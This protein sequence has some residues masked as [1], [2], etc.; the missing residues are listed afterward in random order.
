MIVVTA[1]N[2][3]VKLRKGKWTTHGNERPR[4]FLTKCAANKCCCLQWTFYFCSYT[5]SFAIETIFEA[6]CSLLSIVL[7]TNNPL[8]RRPEYS[9]AMA[10]KKMAKIPS[11][12]QVQSTARSMYTATIKIKLTATSDKVMVRCDKPLSSKI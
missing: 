2:C 6:P 9:M 5:A 3:F 7:A 1:V 11:I 8:R 12:S 4:C 10:V